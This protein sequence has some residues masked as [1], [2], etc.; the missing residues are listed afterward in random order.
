MRRSRDEII[1]NILEICISGAIKTKIVHQAN[2]NFS[3]IDPYI[4]MLTKNG[5]IDT[6]DG[7][8]VIYQTTPKGMELLEDFKRIEVELI[9]Q[10]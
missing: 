8:R 7:S 1:S 6:R 2:L 9:G 10:Q 4:F 3:M 5:M